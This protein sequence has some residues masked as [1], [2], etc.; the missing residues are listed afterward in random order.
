[1]NQIRHRNQT[2]PQILRHPLTAYRKPERLKIRT[3]PK[4]PYHMR[5]TLIEPKYLAKLAQ[6]IHIEPTLLFIFSSTLLP[7]LSTVSLP[8]SSTSS[9]SQK[10]S[11]PPDSGLYPDPTH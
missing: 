9:S 2:L 10:S 6:R 4:F 3:T 5:Q 8:N 7:H 11:N 1:M